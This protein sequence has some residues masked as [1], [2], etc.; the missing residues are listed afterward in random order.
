MNIILIW[1]SQTG[2]QNKEKLNKKNFKMEFWDHTEEQIWI[3]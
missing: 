1:V 3:L 2:H